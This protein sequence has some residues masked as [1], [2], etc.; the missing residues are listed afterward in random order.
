LEGRGREVKREVVRKTTTVV[1]Y[2]S[3]KKKG[4]GRE[5]GRTDEVSIVQGRERVSKKKNVF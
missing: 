5:R 2:L 1:T 3:N 4:G